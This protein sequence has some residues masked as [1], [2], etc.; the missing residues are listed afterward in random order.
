M[1][2]LFGLVFIFLKVYL[3]KNRETDM[4]LY[5]EIVTNMKL[6]ME[7]WKESECLTEGAW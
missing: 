5:S 4:D 6:T 1:S 2:L 3:K 7:N